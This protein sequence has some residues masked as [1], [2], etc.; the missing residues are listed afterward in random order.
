AGAA[1]HSDQTCLATRDNANRKC[2]PS[3]RRRAS[4]A[5]EPKIQI[6]GSSF[7]LLPREKALLPA[8]FVKLTQTCLFFCSKAKAQVFPVIAAKEFA[9]DFLSFAGVNN[10]GYSVGDQAVDVG[11]VFMPYFGKAVGQALKVPT[12]RS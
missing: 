5:A 8:T 11:Y 12:F 2:R 9:I 7:Q 6:P 4:Y 3:T 1:S 10:P